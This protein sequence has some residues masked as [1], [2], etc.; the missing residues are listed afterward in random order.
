MCHSN[1]ATSKSTCQLN[2]ESRSQQIDFRSDLRIC[3][4][5]VN[6]TMLS[7][8]SLHTK[9]QGSFYTVLSRMCNNAEN[10]EPDLELEVVYY[11]PMQ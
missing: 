10:N 3:F 6:S 1:L 7:F 11:Q 4:S 8:L 2:N 9:I 5:S